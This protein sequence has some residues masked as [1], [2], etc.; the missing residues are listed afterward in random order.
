MLS[1]ELGNDTFCATVARFFGGAA[2]GSNPL[3]SRFF[4]L[5][6]LLRFDLALSATDALLGGAGEDR[7]FTSDKGPLGKGRFVGG[8][9]GELILDDGAE[10]PAGCVDA[11]MGGWQRFE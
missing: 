10:D 4:R 9:M 3:A 8:K 6:R 7:A 5:S 1:S 11:I 2:S